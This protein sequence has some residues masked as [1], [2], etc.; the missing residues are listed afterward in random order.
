MDLSQDYQAIRWMQENIQGSPVIVEANM[1]DLY[2][3][4]SRYSINTGLPSVAGWEWHQQQQRAINPGIWVS[5]RIDQIDGFYKTINI[6]T[7]RKFLEQFGVE[8]FVVGQLERN[9]FPHLSLEKFER[10]N[11]LYWN[12]VFRDGDTVIYQVN[13]N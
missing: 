8:Y 9:I 4:G 6:E 13:K 7:A 10:G 12:E 1:R 3:W 2:R 5:N 11:G